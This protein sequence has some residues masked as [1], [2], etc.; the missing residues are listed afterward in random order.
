[1]KRG[2]KNMKA[3][4][5]DRAGGVVG[6]AEGREEVLLCLERDYEPGDT[7]CIS[8]GRQPAWLWFRPDAAVDESAVY[9]P[10]GELHWQVPAGEH[11]LSYCPGAFSARRHAISVR[12]MKEEERTALRNI[13]LNPADL[14]GNTDFYPHV[15]ANV[16]TRGESCFAARNVINGMRFNAGHGEWPVQ[17]WGIGAREDAWC[18]L[19]FGRPV[20]AES[21]AL[22]LRADFPHDAYWTEGHAV[23]DTGEDIF[24]RLEKTAHRQWIPLGGKII[25]TLRL[26]RLVKSND[27]SAFPSLTEWEVFGADL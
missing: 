15:S 22:T 14:R 9:T 16:E 4:V 20:R 17:S 19:D 26:E 7:I 21:M 25:R 3:T 1:M 12:I 24:F 13:A 2:H 10:S 18:L 11:R 8:A 5:F 6:Q 27:P 23:T